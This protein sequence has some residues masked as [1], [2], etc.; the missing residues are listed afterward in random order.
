MHGITK[1][2]WR[3]SAASRAFHDGEAIAGSGDV[4]R[5][6]LADLLARSGVRLRVLADI[7]AG[8]SAGGIKGIYLAREPAH[9]QSLDP[10]HELRRPAAA[11]DRLIATDA[12]RAAERREGK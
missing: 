8:A 1:E 10:I 3:L 2:V 7:V 9:G 6:L 11:L 12:R 5:D 4:Y